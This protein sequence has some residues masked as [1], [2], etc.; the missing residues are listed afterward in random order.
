[1]DE[2]KIVEQTEKILADEIPFE[3]LDSS[4]TTIAIEIDGD[5]KHDHL[6]A[7]YLMEQN[8]FVLLS[9]WVT[10][11]TG[12]DWYKGIHLYGKVNL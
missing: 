2:Y 4:K 10:E 11:D 5:W 8:G 3:L 12:S 9:K 1:M 7:D 6:R